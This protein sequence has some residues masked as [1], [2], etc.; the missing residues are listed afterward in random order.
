M[1]KNILSSEAENKIIEKLLSN[2]IC[3]ER[4]IERMPLKLKIKNLN[5]YEGNF[6]SNKVNECFIRYF[7]RNP[8]QVAIICEYEYN[9]VNYGVDNVVQF[10]KTK[11]RSSEVSCIDF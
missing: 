5:G 6:F 2:N 1:N 3:N 9:D 8:L 7:D 10:L 11:L 4:D